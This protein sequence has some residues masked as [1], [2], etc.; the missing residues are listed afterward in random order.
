MEGSVRRRGKKWYYRLDAA[1]KNGKRFQVERVGGDTNEIWQLLLQIW[2]YMY[3][4]KRE[5]HHSHV[6]QI[7]VW[8]NSCK[9]RFPVYCGKKLK[10]SVYF[11][12]S[13]KYKCRHS[14]FFFSSISSSVFKTAMKASCGTSTR[15]TAFIRF[16][17]RFCL[18]KSL[19]R[20]SGSPVWIR[21]VT[22]L[23]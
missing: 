12:A 16:L 23:R 22:S 5:T 9:V 17:P 18:S 19:A 10:K 6:G 11:L 21:A 1:D 15:P 13:L 7:H 20:R 14:Y 2:F 8:S 3:E 4:K